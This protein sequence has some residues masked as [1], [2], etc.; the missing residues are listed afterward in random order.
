[1][2][3]SL[4][5]L[6]HERPSFA[7]I[8]SDR[9]ADKIREHRAEINL[10]TG[11]LSHFSDAGYRSIWRARCRERLPWIYCDSLDDALVSLAEHAK[12][13]QDKTTPKR[14]AEYQICREAGHIPEPKAIDRKKMLFR[15]SKCQTRYRVA[16]A[17]VIDY[18]PPCDTDYP[19]PPERMRT[20]RLIKNIPHHEKHIVSWATWMHYANRWVVNQINETVSVVTE[21]RG[22][23][24]LDPP[25]LFDVGILVGNQ[26]FPIARV[27]TQLDAAYWHDYAVKRAKEEYANQ[28][29]G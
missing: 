3:A 26:M 19:W 27:A 20:Y 4:V 7:W 13:L 25:L 29:H 16:E 22:S 1:M 23:C 15:C 9:L 14:W 21:F 2:R 5:P 17:E 18:D 12:V 10:I 11:N 6:M 24:H 28:Q 8:Y